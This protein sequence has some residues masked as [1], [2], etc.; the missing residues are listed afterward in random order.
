M[1]NAKITTAAFVVTAYT[2]AARDIGLVQ[3]R[4]ATQVD[5]KHD[6]QHGS[7]CLKE[8]RGCRSGVSNCDIGLHV[9]SSY[10]VI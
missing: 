6:S 1:K 4:R 7:F 2:G 10:Y 5:I 3:K 9:Q 8:C